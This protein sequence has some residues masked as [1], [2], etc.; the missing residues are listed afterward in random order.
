MRNIYPLLK[1]GFKVYDEG[2]QLQGAYLGIDSNG[3]VSYR[4]HDIEG[5][6]QPVYEVQGDEIEIV[7]ESELKDNYHTMNE[8]YQHRH[9]LLAGFVNLLYQTNESAMIDIFKSRFHSDGTMFDDMF[10][11]MGYL[12]GKQ[13]SYHIENKYWDLFK[14]P[15]QEKSDEWNGHTSE[16]VIGIIEEWIKGEE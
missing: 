13:F 5:K 7:V 2:N 4:P 6:L 3:I 12:N 10:I 14:I 8:L 9:I 15:Y 1:N 16:D 11:V